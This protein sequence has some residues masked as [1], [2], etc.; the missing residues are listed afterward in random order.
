M[1][2]QG[3]VK[4]THR[5]IKTLTIKSGNNSSSYSISVD[6]NGTITFNNG[7]SSGNFPMSTS[8]DAEDNPLKNQDF[9]PCSIEFEP[10]GQSFYLIVDNPSSSY[11]FTL[12][13]EFGLT[14]KVSTSLNSK[15]LANINVTNKDKKAL[16]NGMELEQDTNSSYATIYFTPALYTYW[17]EDSNDMIQNNYY[18]KGSDGT[19]TTKSFIFTI[20]DG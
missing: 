5:D 20:K 6:S 7:D 13:D 10:V 3:L 17:F 19:T 2:A 12:A 18:V 9:I 15:K 8:T 14:S 16:T 1:P 4:S 11:T